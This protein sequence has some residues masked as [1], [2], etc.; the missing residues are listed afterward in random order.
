M[1]RQSSTLLS[2]AIV[3]A[4]LVARVA[5][6]A[7]PPRQDAPVQ[8]TVTVTA[9][10]ARRI[11]DAT[12]TIQNHGDAFLSHLASHLVPLVTAMTGQ[13][14][15]FTIGPLTS[16]EQSIVDLPD[17]LARH[18]GASG[19]IRIQIRSTWTVTDAPVYRFS[20]AGFLAMLASMAKGPTVQVPEM[21]REQLLWLGRAVLDL[22]WQAGGIIPEKDVFAALARGFRD[23]SAGTRLVGIIRSMAD[24]GERH[25]LVPRSRLAEFEQRAEPGFLIHAPAT[26]PGTIKLKYGESHYATRPDHLIWS[27]LRMFAGDNSGDWAERAMARERSVLARAILNYLEAQVRMDA[28]DAMWAKLAAP[29]ANLQEIPLGS[30]RTQGPVI[31]LLKDAPGVVL[32]PV[33]REPELTAALARSSKAAELRIWL[34]QQTVAWHAVLE[35]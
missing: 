6:Q 33:A 24:S 17:S 12:K 30:F 7:P 32:R 20:E 34:D 3:A 35:R 19:P 9:E 31:T 23:Q 27:F 1:R 13:D 16:R 26:Q 8:M 18:Q 5:A 14:R 25:D 15:A 2:A 10:D 21:H 11:R 4:S 29:P 28:I 22:N